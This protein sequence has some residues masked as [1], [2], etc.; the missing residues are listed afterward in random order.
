MQSYGAWAHQERGADFP[1]TNDLTPSAASVR[2]LIEEFGSV[3]HLARAI[4]VTA[5]DLRDWAAGKQ[6]VP[7]DKY[8]EMLEAVLAR[9][10]QR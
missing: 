1:M 6:P 4:G 8:L 3:A 2:R 7:Q 9:R 5:A 10:A